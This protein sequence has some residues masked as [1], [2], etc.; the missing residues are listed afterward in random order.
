MTNSQLIV[1]IPDEPPHD[2]HH[3]PTVTVFA[4]FINPKHANQIVRRLNQ[5]APLEGLRHV[6][7]I[8]KKVLEEGGQIELSVVLCLAYEGDNQLDAVPPHLQ[9]FISS[10]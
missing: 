2:L 8:R 4:S 7:R 5:I 1:H 6:K 10:Y 3:Q 9:E